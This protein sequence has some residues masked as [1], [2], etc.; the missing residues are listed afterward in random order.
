MWSSIYDEVLDV[1]GAFNS[2]VLF[3]R[4]HGDPSWQLTPNIN[5]FKYKKH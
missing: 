4:G 1:M 2:D 5:R 3:F